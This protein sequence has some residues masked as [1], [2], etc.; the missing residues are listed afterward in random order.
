MLVLSAS[1]RI[2]ILKRREGQASVSSEDDEDAAVCDSCP[3]EVSP[4]GLVA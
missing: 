4:I 1:L 2:S 3:T